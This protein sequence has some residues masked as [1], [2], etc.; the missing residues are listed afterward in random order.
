MLEN[1]IFY[2]LAFSIFS[3]M[4]VKFI[5]RKD[6][7][8]IVFAVLEVIGIILRLAVPEMNIVL[9]TVFYLIFILAP[10]VV[11]WLETKKIFLSETLGIFKAKLYV[12]NGY[13][14]V[15]RK[16]LISLIEKYPNSYYAHKLLA[17]IY[18]KEGKSEDAIDEYVKVVEINPKD[19][20]SFYQ[21]A[22]LLDKVNKK[23]EAQ[24]MLT[25]LLQKK[26][27]YYKASELLAS[28]LYD[29]DKFMESVDVLQRALNYNPERYELYYYLGMA[30]TRL[31]D[32]QT[33]KEFY[34]KAAKL[35]SLLYH[36]KLNIAQIALIMNDLE[37]A[38]ER[39]TECLQDETSEAYAYYYLGIIDLL[40][41][42]KDQAINY[43]NIAVQLDEKIYKLIYKHEIFT[44]IRKSVKV[45]ETKVN[46]RAFTKKELKTIKHLDDTF[47]LVDKMK[48]SGKLDSSLSEKKIERAEKER[49]EY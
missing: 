28:I 18:E 26:P 6:I 11:I 34:E 49:E 14:R 2:I 45:T 42:N 41:G 43:L 10:L 13:N 29:K 46:K 48:K 5:R 31:N 19:Y 33:A 17:Q 35:N 4:C 22:F 15:A 20:D 37:E 12:K 30:Y 40:K 8:Y 44:T 3:I 39:F 7:T 21:I 27:E 23:D 25:D 1:V 47:I 16:K 38:E 32:F 36:G 24:N 9:L